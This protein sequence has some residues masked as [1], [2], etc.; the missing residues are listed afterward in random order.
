MNFL[1][2]YMLK[3][4]IYSS[5]KLKGTQFNYK[6]NTAKAISIEDVSKALNTYKASKANKLI[7]KN[8]LGYYLAGLLEGDGHVSIPALGTTTL[9]RILNPRIV[10]TSH[11][12]NFGLYA[13]IQSELG[14]VGRFQITGKNTIR[15]IIG[16]KNGI[17][18]FIN[19][20]HNK[21]RTPKNKRFNDLIKIFNYKYS[22]NIP[23]SLLDNSNFY[24]SS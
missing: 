15:Y 7:T 19:L 9:N 2:L 13:Y 3:I 17:I 1:S 21:L 23:E 5:L 6:L 4:V 24:D 10:F 11:I 18:L 12:N 22:L 20:I 8:D 16:D 14:G